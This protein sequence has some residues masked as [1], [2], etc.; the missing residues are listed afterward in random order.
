LKPDSIEKVADYDIKM[1]SGEDSG[2]HNPTS[3]RSQ[4]VRDTR[5][6]DMKTI[7]SS[8]IIG[9]AIVIAAIIIVQNLPRY[10]YIEND[11]DAGRGLR[12]SEETVFDMVTC[13]EYHR[14][15]VYDTDGKIS[16]VVRVSKPSSKPLHEVMLKQRE[17]FG[18]K[19][20]TTE[21]WKKWKEDHN[22]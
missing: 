6:T 3:R 20:F 13:K 2:F 21:E 8:I 10:Q 19:K 15:M 1:D 12:S 11:K 5:R 16:T 22:W 7:I 17:V 14:I 18:D 9:G 4:R